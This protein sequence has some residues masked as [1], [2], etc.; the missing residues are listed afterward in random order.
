MEKSV[1]KGRI[2]CHY[3]SFGCIFTLSPQIFCKDTGRKIKLVVEYHKRH[4]AMFLLRYS[5]F[6]KI[7]TVKTHS[8]LVYW[9]STLLAVYLKNK[10]RNKTKK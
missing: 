2:Y 7:R 8:R 5:L 10:Q 1:G 4:I 9:F 3:T 6:V